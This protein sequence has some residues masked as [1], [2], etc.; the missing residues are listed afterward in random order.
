LC[1]EPEQD[2]QR[3]S[4]RKQMHIPLMRHSRLLQRLQAAM[5]VTKVER[6][7]EIWN[8]R[9]RILISSLDFTL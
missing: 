6:V 8:Q 9:T 1:Q 4:D 2:L 5:Q 7:P 3:F